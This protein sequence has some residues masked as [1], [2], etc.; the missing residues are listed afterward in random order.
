MKIFF[1]LMFLTVQVASAQSLS[2][3]TLLRS[4]AK[5]G[6][7]DDLQSLIDS[8]VDVDAQIEGKTALWWATHAGQPEAMLMLLD[9]GADANASDRRGTTVLHLVAM[10][11]LL[12]V[13]QRVVDAGGKVDAINEGGATPLF[14]A[15]WDG[16]LEMVKAL[17]HNEANPYLRG[18]GSWLPI[19]WAAERGHI[20]IVRLFVEIGVSIT[21]LTP[22]QQARLEQM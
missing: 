1:I 13:L 17:L 21:F 4:Y 14:M 3:E 5:N 7:L 8:G 18:P 9:A 15:T 22:S 19:N 16:D 10:K 20:D 6:H 2:P 11:G 12:D